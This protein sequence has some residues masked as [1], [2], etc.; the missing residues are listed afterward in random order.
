MVEIITKRTGARREDIAARNQLEK[1][2]GTIE[3]LADHL[4][5]GA[6]SASKAPKTADPAGSTSG[7]SVHV[8]GTAAK[9]QPARPYIRISPNDRVVVVDGD[10]GRQLHFLGD[11]RTGTAGRCFV[12][13]SQANGAF[14]PLDPALAERLADLDGEPVRTDDD[15]AR[16]S[17][18][19]GERLDLE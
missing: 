3:R 14:A 6:Y 19:I 13:A 1:N 5:N 7:T 2:W 18:L 11:I 12:L 17:A 4:S 9:A 8:V 16:L 10:S 15:E